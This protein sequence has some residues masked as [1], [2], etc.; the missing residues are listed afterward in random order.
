MSEANAGASLHPPL[1]IQ[2]WKSAALVQYPTREE[3]HIRIGKFC[4]CLRSQILQNQFLMLKASRWV[5]NWKRYESKNWPNLPMTIQSSSI[6]PLTPFCKPH[7]QLSEVSCFNHFDIRIWSD[8]L[9]SWC[10]SPSLH[11]RSLQPFFLGWGGGVG[12]VSG[13]Q[14]WGEQ[15][16]QEGKES[17]HWSLAQRLTV[18][19]S[20]VTLCYPCCWS[21]LARLS[22]LPRCH[23]KHG[24]RPRSKLYPENL[25]VWSVWSVCIRIDGRLVFH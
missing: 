11:R 19:L 17:W 9:M 15:W 18:R 2:P 6:I 24:C 4:I 3:C 14:S 23:C 16:S 1:T 22:I 21:N 7:Q 8:A 10:L 12:S 25:W 13:W 20:F 5:R